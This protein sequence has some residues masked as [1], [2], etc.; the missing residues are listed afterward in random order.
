MKFDHYQSCYHQPLLWPGATEQCV[1][2]EHEG[3]SSG[4]SGGGGSNSSSSREAGT[5]LSLAQ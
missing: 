2:D 3:A 4:S 1:R 5:T